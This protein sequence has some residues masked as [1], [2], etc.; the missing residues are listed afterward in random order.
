MGE[1]EE[2]NQRDLQGFGPFKILAIENSTIANR[3][4]VPLTL[5]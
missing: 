1:Q 3:S 5:T 2:R 4:G